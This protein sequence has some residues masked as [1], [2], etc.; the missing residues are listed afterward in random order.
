MDT[1]LVIAGAG[2]GGLTAALTLHARGVGT[3]NLEKVSTMRPLGVGINLLPHA[4]RELDELGLAAAVG[5]IA[6]APHSIE[7]YASSGEL[8]F[9]EPRGRAAGDSHP[10]LSVHRGTL[11]MLLLDTVTER[12]GDAAIRRGVG[13]TGFTQSA[14]DIQVHTTVENI[15]GAALIGADGINSAVRRTLH[16]G[17]D[18]LMWSG[19]TMFRGV[20]DI[21]AFLDGETMAIVKGED[22]IDLVAYPIGERLVNWVLQVPTGRAGVLDGAAQWNAAADA[23]QVRGHIADWRLGRLD[24]AALIEATEQIYRYPMVDRE[25]LPHWGTG[26]VTLLGDAAHPMYPVGA[27]GG[28]QSIVDA[29]VLAD[30][31]AAHEVPGLRRYAEQRRRETAE[32]IVANRVMHRAS[33]HTTADLQR[34]TAKYRNDTARSNH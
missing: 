26:R 34:M 19:I 30:E 3:V 5:D 21:P 13:V 12:V 28:S 29:R 2:I 20:A 14:D 32:V 6:I 15:C 1:E 18:P 16:P 24:P 4:V 10:Q 7:Y 8:L 23:A 9:R 11:Q 33:G 22:G 27:N 17:A 31:Y 25:P